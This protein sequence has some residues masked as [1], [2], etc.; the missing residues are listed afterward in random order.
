[1]L[2]FVTTAASTVLFCF[3]SRSTTALQK[4]NKGR[5]SQLRGFSLSNKK[6]LRYDFRFRPRDLLTTVK[7]CKLRRAT[8]IYTT[9]TDIKVSFHR[10]R[11]KPS[12]SRWFM[13]RDLCSGCAWCRWRGFSLVIEYDYVASFE[14]IV[15]MNLAMPKREPLKISRSNAFGRG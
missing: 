7:L 10:Y 13:S 5:V 8:E 1:M 11:V 2:L 12:L 6:C 15:W 14:S 4:R 9:T 3:R